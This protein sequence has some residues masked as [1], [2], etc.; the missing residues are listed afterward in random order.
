MS[1]LMYAVEHA[2]HAI[3]SHLLADRRVDVSIED[4]LEQ[5]DALHLAIE[6]EDHISVQILARSHHLDVNR[7]GVHGDTALLLA[8]KAIKGRSSL[9]IVEADDSVTVSV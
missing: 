6:K 7:V 3:L 5:K 4:R 8:I 2:E 9:R 1:A